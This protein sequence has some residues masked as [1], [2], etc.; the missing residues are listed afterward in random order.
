MMRCWADREK[1]E[2]VS[3]E[4][5]W[6]YIVI[7][8]SSYPEAALLTAVLELIGLQLYLVH[9][10]TLLRHPLHISRHFRCLLWG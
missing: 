5:K 4:Q 2:N 10:F 7:V 8:V 9:H 1:P 6:D 3:A